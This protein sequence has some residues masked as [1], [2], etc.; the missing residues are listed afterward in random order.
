MSP[1]DALKKQTNMTF[2]GNGHLRRL[3]RP[4]PRMQPLLGVQLK[5]RLS[6]FE[7][8]V[9]WDL[10]D[11]LVV[12]FGPSGAGKSLTLNMIAG[13]IEPDAGMLTYD[14]AVLYDGGRG[15]SIPPQARSVGYVFQ[16]PALF[17]HMTVRENIYYGAAGV[18]RQKRCERFRDVV[19]IFQL[20][21][22]EKK[23]PH[24]ISG[25]QKQRVAFA[26]ALIRQPKVL[27]LDEPFS[28]LD[29]KLRNEMWDFLR[30]IRKYFRIP[31]VLVTHDV[32][33]AYCLAE[34]V[35]VYDNGRVQH[36]G[37]PYEIFNTQNM[38]ECE[39]PLFFSYMFSKGF[40]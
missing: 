2:R 13:L 12:I 6:R 27:L 25:G 34:R 31:V 32:Y 7:L 37:T 17:P 14:G 35:L 21:G 18:S 16:H 33:E 4:A 36:V 38:P 28:A 20:Y 29:M 10:G 22:L 3:R 8:D 1:T 5:K 9:A 24:E 23:Y 39:Y 19:D 15:I 26:R 30:D 11:E 40:L